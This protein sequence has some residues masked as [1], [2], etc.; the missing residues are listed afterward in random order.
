ML[1]DLLTKVY[2]QN[3]S[4]PEAERIGNALA[5][6]QDETSIQG[7]VD[8]VIQWTIWIAGVLAFIYLVISGI[9]YITAGGNAEQAKKGQAGIINAIIGIVIVVLAWVILQAFGGDQGIVNS[10]V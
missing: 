1:T 8:L 7:I 3:N 10:G 2:A 4:A 9:T 5:I 6:N